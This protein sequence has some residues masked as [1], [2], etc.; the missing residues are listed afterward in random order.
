MMADALIFKKIPNDNKQTSNK[1]K[2][3]NEKQNCH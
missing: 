3:K 2:I 1:S